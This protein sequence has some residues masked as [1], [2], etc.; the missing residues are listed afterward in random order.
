MKSQK[1]LVRRVG[2]SGLEPFDLCF[3]QVASFGA[4]RVIVAVGRKRG[5]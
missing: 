4:M 3:Y 5:G 2:L 1:A